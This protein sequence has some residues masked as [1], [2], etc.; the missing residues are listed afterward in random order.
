VNVPVT[1]GNVN[2]SEKGVGSKAEGILTR[3]TDVGVLVELFVNPRISPV[4]V[5]PVTSNQPGIVFV[6]ENVKSSARA[7]EP[8][9]TIAEIAKIKINVIGLSC[10]GIS[11]MLSIRLLT[12]YGFTN[13]KMVSA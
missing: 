9:R 2:G 4:T 1:L 3:M 7:G 11:P 10:T 13:P 6:N 12:I 8:E 5:P